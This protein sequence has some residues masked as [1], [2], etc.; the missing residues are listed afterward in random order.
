MR[1]YLDDDSAETLLVTL[2]R[3]AGHDVQIPADV[4]KAGQ[5]DAVHFTHAIRES[6]ALL[7]RNQNF[8]HE[9]L[10]KRRGTS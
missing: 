6:R 9:F 3:R 4:G 1:P 10:H 7:S 2:L 5:T 8:H